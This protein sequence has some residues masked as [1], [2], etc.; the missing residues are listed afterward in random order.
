MAVGVL[1]EFPGT[2][3]MYDQVNAKLDPESNPPDGLILHTAGAIEGG[4]RVFDVWESAEAFER[5][6]EDRLDPAI[7]EVAGENAPQPTKREVYE[8]HD[9]VRP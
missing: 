3:E 7:R 9:L 4:M 2:V 6:V 8:L 1:N 5:F